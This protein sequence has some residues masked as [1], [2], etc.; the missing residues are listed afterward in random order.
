MYKKKLIK[1]KYRL[2]PRENNHH[3]TKSRYLNNTFYCRIEAFKY[4]VSIILRMK[5]NT[6]KHISF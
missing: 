4:S 1:S 5:D 2:F 3:D 6:N